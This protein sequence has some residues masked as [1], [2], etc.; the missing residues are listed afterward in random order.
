[1]SAGEK[2][3]ELLK[4][5]ERKRKFEDGE[6]YFKTGAY[7]RAYRCLIDIK[8]YAPALYYLCQISHYVQGPSKPLLFTQ[9][10][11]STPTVEEA[12]SIFYNY[13]SCDALQLQEIE[14]L[15][16]EDRIALHHKSLER[17]IELGKKDAL[18]KYYVG[19]YHLVRD[20]ELPYTYR[21][22]AE[23]ATM[24]KE[25]HLAKYY[26]GLMLL[27]GKGVQKNEKL[28]KKLMEE[29]AKKSATAKEELSKY[30][31]EML[32]KSKKSE[33][34]DDEKEKEQL[35]DLA[36]ERKLSEV[37]LNSAQ[38]SPAS[39]PP[40]PPVNVQD[41]VIS[42]PRANNQIDIPI[43]RKQDEIE[44]K[45]D[46]VE[47]NQDQILSQRPGDSQGN[48]RDSI[49][50]PVSPVLL[51]SAAM[52]AVGQGPALSDMP[53]VNTSSDNSTWTFGSWVKWPWS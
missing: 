22:F 8:E 44:Q 42:E 33:K 38:E 10:L 9:I 40:I 12:V 37:P 45:Q 31:Q 26:K 43:E 49:S 3:N 1:M 28:G 19:C 36:S 46:Q 29:A 50:Q 23:A 7:R 25:L 53:S 52:T 30:K 15:E 39:L 24:D 41:A 51:S 27:E 2:I 14:G 6:Y 17:L 34:K 32:E 18:A 48:L 20:L 16:D 13:L 21:C 4:P 11:Y 35:L 5:E 47:Q